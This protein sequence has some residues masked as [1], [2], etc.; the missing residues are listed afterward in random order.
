MQALI[1]LAH[2]S[3]HRATAKDVAALTTT[4]DQTVAAHSVRYAFLEVAEPTLP[5]AIEQA[6][7]EGAT[8]VDVLPL[9]LNTGNHIARDI[10]NLVAQAQALHPQLRIQLLKHIGSHPAYT[11]LVEAVA[12]NPN[13][14]VVNA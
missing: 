9:F 12:R 5:E 13:K 7:R 10:P 2:G 1:L 11:A 3:R 6:V 14:Y 8:S 4:V